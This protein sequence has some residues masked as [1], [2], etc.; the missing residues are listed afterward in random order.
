MAVQ[1]PLLFREYPGYSIESYVWTLWSR[2]VPAW[3]RYRRCRAAHSSC[4]WWVKPRRSYPHG[5]VS[6][7]TASTVSIIIGR[8]KNNDV[9]YTHMEEMAK[10]GNHQKAHKAERER[11]TKSSGLCMG[12]YWGTTSICDIH[13][14]DLHSVRSRSGDLEG[15]A[16]PAAVTRK[17]PLA[18]LPQSVG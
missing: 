10:E 4:S 16:P 7:P 5:A 12:S 17:I 1:F 9:S 6:V 3:P 18:L 8:I 15:T 13:Q 11:E 2:R 14:R